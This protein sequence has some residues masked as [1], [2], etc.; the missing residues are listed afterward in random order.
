MKFNILNQFG[1]CLI[2]ILFSFLF[3]TEINAQDKKIVV[4]FADQITDVSES[5]E[6]YVVETLGEKRKI[7]VLDKKG[8]TIFTKED[9]YAFFPYT[10]LLSNGKKLLIVTQGWEGSEGFA[11]ADGTI[12]LID[13][14]TKQSK[15]KHTATAGGFIVSPDN[16]YVVTHDIA[17]TMGTDF[18]LIN[19]ESGE[20][21]DLYPI[22][23]EPMVFKTAWLDSVRLV[24]LT[25]Q[26][27]PNPKYADYVIG[28]EK[29]ESQMDSL[30]FPIHTSLIKAE[31]Q[32]KEKNDKESKK[33]VEAI[34]A[35]W[36]KH[37]DE[38]REKREQ[39]DLE[40]R[41]DKDI[42]AP[43]KIY[44]FNALTKKI[45]N[46]KYL[47]NVEGT[48][49]II[50]GQYDMSKILI[51][52]DG[53]LI[54]EVQNVSTHERDI[55]KIDR[56]LITKSYAT[57]SDTEH[58]LHKEFDNLL[59]AKKTTFNYNEKSLFLLKEKQQ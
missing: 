34:R 41:V 25:Y 17:L 45:E 31:Q 47:M 38:R 35:L 36:G 43:A 56:N 6:G 2:V 13:L 16:K 49:I 50:S 29:L 30:L 11:G 42:P 26:E 1:S 44:I 18:V 57:G 51:N 54:V 15:W 20:L 23:K 52:N 21:T 4:N 24:I 59:H 5:A 48:P 3:L 33:Q 39:Y 40:H 53:E 58:S 8:K 27:Q 55:A 46:E 19:T 32:V 7:H 9:I 28:S 10:Q 14:K 12:E 37:Y 22:L